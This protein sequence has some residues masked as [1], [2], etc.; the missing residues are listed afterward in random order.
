MIIDSFTTTDTSGNTLNAY[1]NPGATLKQM[2]LNWQ[3]T[4]YA[5]N[6]AI[7]DNDGVTHGTSLGADSQITVTPPK[8]T[9]GSDSPLT[10]G[11]TDTTTYTLSA[12]NSDNI[13]TTRTTNISV[14]NQLKNELSLS[15]NQL[16]ALQT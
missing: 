13:V 6:I 10:A 7:T 15:L 2:R 1:N 4:G 3:T 8:S 12:T 11:V 16:F 5:S 9:Q 14:K